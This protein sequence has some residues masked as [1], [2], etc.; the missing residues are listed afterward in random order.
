MSRPGISVEHRSLPARQP[1]L[2]RCDVGGIIGFM[3]RME[4]PDGASAG[5]F[6]EVE[7]RRI[8]ELEDH[9]QQLLFDA[10]SRR[11]ARC[12]FENGGDQVHLFSVCIEDDGFDVLEKECEDD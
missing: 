6:V 10:P 11:A 7:L 8:S 9:P 5:D 4:W 12:F 3:R 2:V 1:G